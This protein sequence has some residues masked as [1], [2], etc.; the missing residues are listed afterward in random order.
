MPVNRVKP[1]DLL[2]MTPAQIAALPVDMLAALQSDLAEAKAE[3]EAQSRAL[4]A[5]LAERF[6]AK[7]AAERIKKGKDTGA[8]TLRDSEHKIAADLPKQVKW[9]QG[10]LRSA[11]AKLI[12]EWQVQDV[13][14]YVKF[15]VSESK[16]AAWPTAIRALFEPAR[17][18]SAG[19]QTFKITEG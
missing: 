12:N 17:T 10:L 16:Y 9:D 13:G 14:E 11:V 18:V 2:A 19:T 1:G 8:V 3:H 7:A 6:A 15:D 4:W 5:G